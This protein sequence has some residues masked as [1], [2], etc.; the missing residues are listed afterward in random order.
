MH[1]I[2]LEVSSRGYCF[3]KTQK[4]DKQSYLTSDQCHSVLASRIKPMKKLDY[5]VPYPHFS[6]GGTL[7]TIQ[8]YSRYSKTFY[9]DTSGF[10]PPAPPLHLTQTDVDKAKN[11]L[12]NELLG[13]FPFV[14]Q[15]DRANALSIL[16][17]PLVRH[18]IPGNT[19]I[20]G[21]IAPLSRTGKTLLCDVLIALAQGSPADKIPGPTH[22]DE[23]SKTLHSVLLEHP[24]FVFFDNCVGKIDSNTNSK[25]HD[26]NCPFCCFH[27]D[28]PSIN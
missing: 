25:N 6:S 18:M 22:S 17:T 28:F 4:G 23:W 8:G 26:Y 24:N 19:P 9:H 20:H 13:D 11:L 12:L 16:L 1:D 3:R 7:V 2:R 15:A 14:E 5:I 21:V 10:C 27:F